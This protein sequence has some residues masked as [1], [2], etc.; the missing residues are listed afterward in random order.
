MRP[1]PARPLNV[2]PLC[3]MAP[4][5]TPTLFKVGEVVIDADR[6]EWGKGV[7]V[8]D[9]TAPR[10]PT[11]GQRLYIEFERRGRVMVYTAQRVLQRVVAL[12]GA[13]A[14]RRLSYL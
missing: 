11:C 4:R 13:G 2:G 9:R 5:W 7:I 14:D 12:P 6:P 8:E 1:V 10:S 3:D